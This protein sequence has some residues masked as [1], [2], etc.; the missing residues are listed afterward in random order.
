M[1]YLDMPTDRAVAMLRQREA[2]THTHGDIHETDSAYLAACRQAA[3]EAAAL[4]G[5]KTIPCLDPAGTCGP[6]TRFT[7]TSGRR[8]LPCSTERNDNMGQEVAKVKKI[9]RQQIRE[10]MA[11]LTDQERA[12]SER[13]ADPAL[14][15]AP[16]AGRGPY[17]APLLRRGA[18]SGHRRP[19]PDPAGPGQDRV[20]ADAA[21]VPDG[22]RAIT[23]LEDLV[24]LL[25]QQPVV[26]GQIGLALGGVDDQG[27]HPAPGPEDLH[28]AGRGSL[29]ISTMPAASIRTISSSWDAG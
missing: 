23:A 11:E 20:P 22:G 27:V 13:G 15:G 18:G 14:P 4:Y 3:L 17:G 24:P 16:Q 10:A 9:L 5:W 12:W 28:L 26:G 8:Q 6:L 2:A 7:G 25:Q 19:H 21:G 1:L 29:P